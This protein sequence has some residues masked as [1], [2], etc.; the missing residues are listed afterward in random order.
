MTIINSDCG[1]NFDFKEKR[2]LLKGCLPAGF[3]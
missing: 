1:E 2:G 3:S